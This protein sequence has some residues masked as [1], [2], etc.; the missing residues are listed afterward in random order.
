MAGLRGLV[1]KLEEEVKR[2][3]VG[4]EDA[5]HVA[6]LSLLH[7]RSAILIRAPRG[8]GKSTL[9]LLIL[10]GI[11]GDDFVVVSGASEVKRG[12]VV[13]RLHIPSLEREGV[14]RVLWAAFVQKEGKGLDEVNRLNPYTAA[15]IYHM[16]Q[17]GEVW[18]YGHRYRVGDYVLIANENPYDPTTFVHPPPF[19][20]RFDVVIYL[21]SL[22]LSEKFRLQSLLDKY[23]GELVESMEQVMTFDD[24]REVRRE[25]SEI[26]L[27][28]ELRGTINLLIRDLQA[29]VRN[30]DSSVVK[31]L[32]L[33]EG[34]HFIRDVCSS[35]KTGPSERATIVLSQLAKAKVWL[36]GKCD[37]DDVIE[38]G[39]WV[40]P[41]RIELTKVRVIQEDIEEIL[42]RERVKMREREARRQ[43]Y[44]LNE[45]YK[46]FDRELYRRVKEM[47]LED[48]VLA[49]ELARLEA[50]WVR[51]GLISKE[52]TLYSYLK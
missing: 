9:M 50:G 14:E 41:H 17:F 24:L 1:R 4:N 31:P 43:W 35:I 30:R 38:L 48:L 21:R 52:E 23:G 20:D 45:L 6:I 22:T 25:V 37:V 2:R 15:N 33:C 7:P 51:K 49:E 5:V 47:A 19:Y 13:G 27:D 32:V 40:L 10:R 34:C 36:D 18:A 39:K 12:E 3:F 42:E 44:M 8:L 11:F 16:L 29:C 26:E 28:V 46:K